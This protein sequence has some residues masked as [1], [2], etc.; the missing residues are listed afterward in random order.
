MK[1]VRTHTIPTS[2]DAGSVGAT[3]SPAVERDSAPLTADPVS[4]ERAATLTG[5]QR[6]LVEA[7]LRR[8]PRAKRAVGM[9][10]EALAAVQRTDSSESL[11]VA[12]YEL[13]EFM[14]ELP[15]IMEVPRAPY[16]HIKSKVSELVD[17]WEQG[18]ARS[19]NFDGS[20]WKGEIDRHAG[21]LLARL[22]EFVE[23]WRSNVP[24][25]RDE[26]KAVLQ[27]MVPSDRP[28]PQSLWDRRSGEW[29]A[30][31]RYFNNVTHHE[32]SP[33]HNDF[34]SYV[35]DLEEFLLDHLEPRTFDDQGEI[36]R[37]I[38]EAEGS[39]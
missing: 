7:L 5:R 8:S 13:R 31:L 39:Q 36:D 24:R 17:R 3:R 11:H 16:D 19:R 29:S 32:T 33:S 6:A 2:G 1:S 25:R 21:G 20:D 38:A 28:L 9:Y 4:T 30:L 34:L 15:I 27:A 22:G 35:R 26:V 23:W 37:L 14:G 18:S 12:A 10:V